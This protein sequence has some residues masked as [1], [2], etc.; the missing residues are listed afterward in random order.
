MWLMMLG[1][2]TGSTATGPTGAAEAADIAR[3]RAEVDQ[4]KAA[5]RDGHSESAVSVRYQ[6]P[7]S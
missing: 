1:M 3:L 7:A 6:G 4:L 5:D 2:K